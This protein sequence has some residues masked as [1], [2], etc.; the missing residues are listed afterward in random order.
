MDYGT[1]EPGAGEWEQDLGNQHCWETVVWGFPFSCIHWEFSSEQVTAAGHQGPWS[2]TDTLQAMESSYCFCHPGSSCALADKALNVSILISEASRFVVHDRR[3]MQTE[4]VL[5][6]LKK[7]FL[8]LFF[9]SF[10]W[11]IEMLVCIYLLSYG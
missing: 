6:C 5:S 9:I 2:P 7:N 11:F 1:M 4:V 3:D 10:V 8:I